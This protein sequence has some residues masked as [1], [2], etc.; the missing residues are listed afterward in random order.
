MTRKYKLQLPDLSV[1]SPAFQTHE[2]GRSLFFFFLLC[3][4]LMKSKSN[5]MCT[6]H[7]RLNQPAHL[8]ADG[9]VGWSI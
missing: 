4:D 5:I 6:N 1:Y 8:S 3:L 2:T 9:Q 7:K